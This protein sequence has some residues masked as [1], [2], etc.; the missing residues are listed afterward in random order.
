VRRSLVAGLVVLVAVSSFAGVLAA[1]PQ[2]PPSDYGGS[3]SLDAYAPSPTVSP[4]DRGPFTVQV[5]NDGEVTEGIPPA[6]GA[7]TTARNVRVAV[8]ADGTPL[9][10]ESGTQSIGAVTETQ[11]RSAPIE[12]EV[13]DDVD[14]GTYHLTVELEYSF[15][16]GVDPSLQ[17]TTERTRTVTRRVPVVVPDGPQF[18][19]RTLETGVQ[20][21]GSGT[22]TVEVENVGT[23]PAGD[24]TVAL[25]SESQQL[26]FDAAPAARGAVGELAPGQAATL[27]YGVDVA[28]GA[29]RRSYPV[30]AA[31]SYEDADGFAG[32]DDRPSL[33]VTPLAE[34]AVAVDD[35]TSTVRVAEE[36]TLEATVVNEG[37]ADLTNAVVSLRPPSGNV[38]VIEPEVALGDLAAGESTDVSFDVEVAT[39]ARAGSRQFTLATQYDDAGG[40]TRTADPVRFRADV[41]PERDAFGVDTGNAT[42]TAGGDSRITLRVTNRLDEPVTDV[43]AKLF[44][45]SPLGAADDEAYV[46]SLSPGETVEIPFRVG[47]AGSALPK[48]YPVSVDFQYVDEAGETRLSDSYRR[49]VTVVESSGGLFG[50]LAPIGLLAAGALVVPLALLP[51]RRP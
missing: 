13:P 10:V 39:A 34:Q 41:G 36:G 9:S 28:P 38:N 18:S 50:F 27:E 49:P 29:T 37:P 19:V 1:Q 21:G 45:S 12:L 23:E 35:V 20:V 46:A 32:V 17:T 25:T 48:D 44:A 43:S 31:V 33:S 2:S 22:T 42:V 16:E 47:A 51:L 6:R 11:P 30:D 14:P 4:G 24:V 15:T 40:E 3:P 26:T 7:V 8:D 5:A